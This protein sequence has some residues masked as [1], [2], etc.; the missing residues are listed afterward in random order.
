MIPAFRNELNLERGKTKNSKNDVSYI[1][2]CGSSIDVLA[3]TERSRGQRRT[4]GLLEECVLIDQTALNE[5]IIPTTNVDRYLPDGKWDRDEVVNQSQIYITTAGFKNSFAFDK[6]IEL[7][8]QSL[9]DP[10]LVMVMGGTCEIPI[11]EGLLKEDFV[12]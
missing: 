12:D 6:L 1:F 5:I 8:I 9:I 4:G 2:K 11:L 3:A 7:L 10:D